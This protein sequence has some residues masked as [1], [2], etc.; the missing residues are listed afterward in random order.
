MFFGLD[1]NRIKSS[2]LYKV[3]T[4]VISKNSAAIIEGKI[5]ICDP[6]IHSLR[7]QQQVLT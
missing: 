5:N 4:T 7:W 2:K 6:T 3:A 1:K